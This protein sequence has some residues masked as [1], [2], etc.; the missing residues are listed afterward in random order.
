MVLILLLSTLAIRTNKQ[1]K[2]PLADLT[3]SHGMH[4]VLSWFW[5]LVQLFPVLLFRF[6]PRRSCPVFH[7][8][9]SSVDPLCT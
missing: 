6:H 1:R 7:I 9:S 2:F 5:V 3:N 4:Y 8:M